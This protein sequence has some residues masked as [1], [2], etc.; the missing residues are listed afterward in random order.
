MIDG[1]FVDQI[2]MGVGVRMVLDVVVARSS[3]N[4][5]AQFGFGSV[6]AALTSRDT[7]VRV[8]FSSIG[9]A[10]SVLPERS[11][12]VISSPSEFGEVSEEFYTTIQKLNRALGAAA[13]DQKVNAGFLAYHVANK[14]EPVAIA[15]RAPY[16]AG[17]VWGLGTIARRTSCEDSLKAARGQLTG[18]APHQDLFQAGLI[19]VYGVFTPA[20]RC[21][22]DPV[23]AIS[24][25]AAKAELKDWDAR[26]KAAAAKAAKDNAQQ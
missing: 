8:S 6:A 15:D 26:K 24:Q 10:D 22:N 4:A 5:S 14:Q 17:Y 9:I 18:L 7:T 21:G 11:P 1:A 13:P 3:T 25:E 19:D 12:I 16:A 23:G 20:V 2:R